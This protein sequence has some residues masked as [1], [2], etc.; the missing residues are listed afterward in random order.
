MIHNYQIINIQDSTILYNRKENLDSIYSL[1]QLQKDGC[2]VEQINEFKG[3]ESNYIFIIGLGEAHDSEAFRA[4]Y[5]NS[6]SRSTGVC[7]IVDDERVQKY[8][9]EQIDA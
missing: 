3:M 4:L 9:L 2:K 1:P 5:Y 7:Y 6:V 8:F